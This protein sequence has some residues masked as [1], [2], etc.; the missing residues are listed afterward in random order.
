M[1]PVFSGERLVSRTASPA[2]CLPGWAAICGRLGHTQATLG[3]QLMISIQ[4]GA[5][6]PIQRVRTPAPTMFGNDK[7]GHTHTPAMHYPSEAKAPQPYRQNNDCMKVLVCRT[8]GCRGESNIYA[9]TTGGAAGK[10]PTKVATQAKSCAQ[11]GR[12][13]GFLL[14]VFLLY[15]LRVLLRV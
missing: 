4:A 8:V 14:T 9:D 10:S 11:A 12:P 1:G 7:K 15:I 6:D 13:L 2:P 5:A 3:E